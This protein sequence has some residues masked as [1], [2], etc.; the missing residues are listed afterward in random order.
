MVAYMFNTSIR[1][2]S[3]TMVQVVTTTSRT[4]VQVVTPIWA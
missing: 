4:M 1:Y 2:S 3:R